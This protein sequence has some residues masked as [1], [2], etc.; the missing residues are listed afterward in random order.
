MNNGFG[1][2]GFG[3]RTAAAGTPIDRL[4]PPRRGSLLR[5][6]TLK[7]EGADAF[8][9]VTA[10]RPLGRTRASSSTSAGNAVL[11]LL[12]DPGPTGNAVAAGD[13]V[14]VREIDNVVRKYEVLSVASL[15]VTL[16]GTLVAGAAAGADVWDFGVEADEDPRTGE[17]HPYWELGAATVTLTDDGGGVVASAASDEPILLRHS[18]DDT[19]TSGHVAGALLQTSYVYTTA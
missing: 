19:G 15:N 12:A 1:G 8:H 7:A 2:G 13:L 16:T 18:N 14:A 6:T 4:V 11:H 5:V 10:L 9:R 3:H 17:A